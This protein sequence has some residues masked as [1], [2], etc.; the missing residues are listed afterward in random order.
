MR[1]I[2][3]V[4]NKRT[5]DIECK[6]Q[7]KRLLCEVKTVNISDK[8]IRRRTS[9]EVFDGSIYCNLNHR[10]NNKFESDFKDAID[11]LFKYSN[12]EADDLIVCPGTALIMVYFVINFDDFTG[13]YRDNYER[14]LKKL[15]NKIKELN[16]R[17]HI[18]VHNFDYQVER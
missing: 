10:F 14:Q 8:E 17:V 13:R 1:F 11:Q 7:G 6:K 4:K 18:V 16:S 15:V 5:P 9:S 3:E 2:P 12:S